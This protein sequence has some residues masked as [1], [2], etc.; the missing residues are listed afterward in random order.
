MWRLTDAAGQLKNIIDEF[1]YQQG[2]KG[3]LGT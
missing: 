2:D 3:P 1:H